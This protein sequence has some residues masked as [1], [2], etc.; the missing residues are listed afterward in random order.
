MKRTVVAV[1]LG[2]AL[3]GGLLLAGRGDEESSLEAPSSIPP[4]DAASSK[5]DAGADT[6]L[7]PAS[8]SRGAATGISRSAIAALYAGVPRTR[9]GMPLEDDPFGAGSPEEQRW[10]DRNGYPN[11]AEWKALNGASISQL[12]EAA[13]GGDSMA[14]IMVDYWDVFQSGSPDAVNTL[15]RRGAS[16]DA[17]ALEMLSSA[18]GVA[19]ANRDPV[20]ASALRQVAQLRGNLALGLFPDAN[21][22]DPL[23]PVQRMEAARRAV[24]LNHYLD[25]LRRVEFGLPPPTYDPR[26]IRP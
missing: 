7:A 5:V 8:P 26:P 17:F 16:G 22:P 25:N 24:E 9:G 20:F 13:K 11:A 6:E 19:R 21:L 4:A 2:F 15:M 14:A 18:L 1:L 3:L 12:Q 10:L 23:D